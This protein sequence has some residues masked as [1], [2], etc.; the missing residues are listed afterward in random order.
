METCESMIERV[1]C[2]KRLKRFLDMVDQ[3][4]IGDR[5]I[6]FNGRYEY[7]SVDRR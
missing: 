3:D 1:F 2:D 5:Q 4:R 7:I 6:D